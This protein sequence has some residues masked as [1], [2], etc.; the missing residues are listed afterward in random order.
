VIAGVY[1][2]VMD[3]RGEEVEV[4]SAGPAEIVVR[5]RACGLCGTDVSK[6]RFG[7]VHPPAVLGHEVA[8]DVVRVGEGVHA[9]AEGD[10]VV[11]GHHVPC[12]DCLACVA[13]YESQCPEFLHN[14][15]D[16]G[17]FAE[18]VNVLP[19]SAMRA[20]FRIPDGLGY[21]EASQAESVGCALRALERMK[22]EA[23]AAA[24]VVGAGTV[25]LLHVQLLRHMG[26]GFIAVS[27][28]LDW[29]R[30]VAESLGADVAFDPAAVD[31]PVS[32]AEATRGR[33]LAI[34]VVAAGS[35]LA[36]EHALSCCGVGTQVLVFAECA[37]GSRVA[38]DP[39]TLYRKEL[40]VVGGYSTTPE[41]IRR[42]LGLIEDGTVAVAPLV[43]HRFGLAGISEA[44]E[45]AVNPRD[46]SLKII[47]EP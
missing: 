44:V 22:L 7:L 27:D 34:I 18:Y 38:L 19:R 43:T 45:L 47:I 41:H 42:G 13:G 4:P 23:G 20:T 3:V 12:G 40:S 24:L 26:A 2:G 9:I 17:G 36:V 29:R 6:I 5:V 33:R 28:P 1:R 39:S 10:R 16:P 21:E 25:G 32:M 46:G 15:L 37:P 14:N 35:P 31:L 8:G 11:V 30:E